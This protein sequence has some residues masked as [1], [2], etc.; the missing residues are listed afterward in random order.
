[1]SLFLIGYIPLQFNVINKIWKLVFSNMQLPVI[2]YIN[3]C[4]PRKISNISHHQPSWLV[5]GPLIAGV[6]HFVLWFLAHFKSIKPNFPLILWL[7]ILTLTSSMKPCQRMSANVSIGCLLHCLVYPGRNNNDKG[8]QYI[9]QT[10][11]LSPSRIKFAF[12]NQAVL[13]PVHLSF[14]S[15]KYYLGHSPQFMPEDMF[16]PHMSLDHF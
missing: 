8:F 14:D 4:G 2:F 15:L 3:I 6:L 7:H 12:P 11:G 13:V 9:C 1:M 16:F 5:Q 10:W